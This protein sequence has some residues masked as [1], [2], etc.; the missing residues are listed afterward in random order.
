MIQLTLWSLP[1]L[2]ALLTAVIAYVR[3][4]NNRSVP[5]VH[6]LLLLLAAVI[7]WCTAQFLSS[8]TT[9]LDLKVLVEKIAYLGSIITPVAWFIF[10]I[11]YSKHLLNLSRRVLNLVSLI[12]LCTLLMIMTNQWHHLFWVD[13]ALS[14]S[15]DGYVGIVTTSGPWFYVHAAYSYLLIIIATTIIAFTLSFSSHRTLPMVAVIAAPTIVLAFNLVTISPWNPFPWYDSTT[16]GFALAAWVLDAGVLRFGL[17]DGK[18]VVREQVVERLDDGVAVITPDGTIV[19]LNHAALDLLRVGQ[20]DVLHT[21]IKD[22]IPMLP[23]KELVS[24][25]RTSTEITLRGFAYDVRASAL[26]GSNAGSNLVLVFRDITARREADVTLRKVKSELEEQ[27]NTDYL[28]KLY[29]RRFFIQRLQEEG[30]RVRRHG[31]TLSVL[32]Y[33]L[34]KFKMVND[35]YGHDAGDLV[36]MAVAEVSGEMKRVTDIAA[37][38][39]GEEFALLLPETDQTGAVQLA[40]R[41]RQAL[42]DAVIKTKDGTQ[43]KVTA[44]IGVA[45]VCKVAEVEQILTFADQ[46]LYKAKNGGRNRVC[47]A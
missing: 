45:T 43:I 20:A 33:D 19:D 14:V 44:S 32:L 27:A 25:R 28:T 2:V 5:G 17:L 29:N 12:P 42:E 9:D 22:L 23:L 26:D 10:A 18:P 30:E 3:I 21:S 41:L 1:P 40:Q 34:D 39:G 8:V 36:L 13:Y 47:T 46:A 15:A 11:T 31:S 4:K 37:R 6:A 38:I 7:F 35:T 16:L 24:R